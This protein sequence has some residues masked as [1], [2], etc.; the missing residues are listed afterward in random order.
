M[1]ALDGWRGAL[2]LDPVGSG[3][4]WIALAVAAC[5]RGPV[6]VMVPAILR[7]QWLDAAAR[8]AVPLHL[9]THERASRGSLP[10]LRPS[11]VII[12]EAHRLREPATHR[13]RTIAPWLVGRRALLLTA[14][15]IVNRLGD[16]ITL[17]RLAV[18]EDALALD[19]IP[20]LADLELQATPPAALRRIAIRSPGPGNP[21]I[22]RRLSVLQPDAPECRRGDAAVTAIATLQLS[23]SGQVRRLVR[24]VL[25]DAAAS[26]DAALHQA[27]KRYRALLMQARDAG[28]ASR[29]M[30]RRFAGESLEQLVF[31]P[32]L[33]EDNASADLPLADI[34]RVERLLTAATGDE[35]WIAA[36]LTQCVDDRPT[37]CFT[38]H[39]ATAR[40]LRTVL[41]DATAWITGTEAGIGPH[42][43]SRDAVLQAFGPGRDAW[44]LLRH[45]PRFLVA[46]DVAAEGL[47]LQAAGRIVHVDLPWTATRVE[48][49]EGRLLRLGQQHA[50]VEVLIRLP[51][52][53]I[54][55]ALAPQARVGRKRRLADAWL[56][57]LEHLDP[58]TTPE[59]GG[60]SVTVAPDGPGDTCLIA[61][62]L[63]RDG[64][65]GV[66]TMTRAIPAGIPFDT[67][68]R[69]EISTAVRVAIAASLRGNEPSRALVSRI[70]RLARQAAANRDGTTL[71]RLDRLL[72]FATAAP[73]LGARMI[74]AT[75]ADATDRDVLLF[76]IPDIAPQAATHATPIAA[77]LFPSSGSP[78]R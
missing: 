18:P 57:A 36:L 70:Q 20:R 63:D 68:M 47:D 34:Q 74:M 29:A 59:S 49:R 46:T 28:V 33:A 11:L 26:S 69:D 60:P 23:D 51:A 12:D 22:R 41:G 61:V 27:L 17:L 10:P 50:D 40:V 35:P 72:R 44:Q 21:A 9:W 43:V 54:E 30:L 66:M 45:L 24:S 71:Q 39:R 25:L 65:S 19:G 52:P 1:A 58:A 8:A 56:L 42:R 78:L 75:L 7:T 3:K 53:S 77:F 15:P 13:T 62:R 38:R 64:R 55:T 37:V 67:A 32:L 4:T 14:T 31:W 2:L 48:Q 5:E 6:I 76:D 73:T 16:L